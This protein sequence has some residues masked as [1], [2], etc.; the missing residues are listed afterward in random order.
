MS[1]PRK[2]ALPGSNK[3]AH[4][5]EITGKVNR[6]ET[7]EVTVRIRRKKSIESKLQS[8]ERITHKNY[9]KEFGSSQ[10]DMD[11]VEAFAHQFHLTTAEVSL[12]RRSIILRGNVS[13]MEAAFGV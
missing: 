9:E 8:G 7:I 13:D 2:I 6:N 12:A 5:G 11:K 1:A 10:K 3:A 4:K